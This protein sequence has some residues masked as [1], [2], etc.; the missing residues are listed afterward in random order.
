[1]LCIR[2]SHLQDWT[3]IFVI[4]CTCTQRFL[5]HL[6]HPKA[7]VI[8]IDTVHGL[9]GQCHG[10]NI[11]WRSKH[12]NQ[13]FCVCAAGFQV[14]TKAFHY[15]IQSLTFYLLLLN[16]LLILK[17]LTETLLRISFSV[18]GQN[19]SQNR[20]LRAFEA[21]YSKD[22]YYYKPLKIF[23]SWHNPFVPRRLFI[24]ALQ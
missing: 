5:R 21:G 7:Y 2:K 11:F 4:I 10:M 1:M 6:E 14:L 18:I 9:K 8:Q 19:Q 13:N 12:F 20:R 15:P 23:I 17:M 22:Y 24:P 3:S 16:Y